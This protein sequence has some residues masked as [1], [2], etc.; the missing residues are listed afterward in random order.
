MFV[1]DE[2]RT[3]MTMVILKKVC[4]DEGRTKNNKGNIRGKGETIL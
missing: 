2:V 3:S 4:Q 1:E